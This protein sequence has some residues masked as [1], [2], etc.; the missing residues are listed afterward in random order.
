LNPTLKH[1][2]NPKLVKKSLQLKD[3]SGNEVPFATFHYHYRSLEALQQLHVV[4]R[5]PEV[6]HLED[7]DIETMSVEALRKLVRGTLQRDGNQVCFHPAP[8]TKSLTD[9]PE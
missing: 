3:R 6:Y 7:A 5:T 8:G 9:S 1:T 2:R 4:E